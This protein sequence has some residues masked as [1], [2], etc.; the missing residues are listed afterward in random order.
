MGD[1]KKVLVALDLA[2]E[3]GQIVE[4]AKAVAG[5]GA[6]I[7]MVHVIEPAYFYYGM[8]PAIGALP[9]NFEADLL[10]RAQEEMAEKAKA[11]GVP[12]K[13]RFIERGHA[14]TQILRLAEDRGVD[15]IVLGS[16]GRHGWQLLLGSTA[17]A[18]LHRAKCD[19]LAVRV[20][21]ES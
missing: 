6:E 15:L 18:V 20:G 7:A 8:E 12:E 10:K 17:N 21:K 11:M 19:V 9:D 14:P 4:R 16:H 3:T 2:G 1:Y 13:L 5:K